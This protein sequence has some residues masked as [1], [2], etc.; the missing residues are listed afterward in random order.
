MNA[1]LRVLVVEDD[2]D[3]FFLTQRALRKCVAADIIRVDGGRDAIDYLGGTGNYAERTKFPLPDV[4]FLDLKMG[5]VTGHDVLAW[6]AANLKTTAPRIFVL[7]GSNEAR[8]RERVKNSGV[9]SGYVVKPLSPEY[10]AKILGR[11]ALSK[12]PF[13]G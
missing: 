4:M 2:D 13:D 9:A 11:D 1:T 8:D 7:T 5:E 6:V 10:L 12:P 3:D